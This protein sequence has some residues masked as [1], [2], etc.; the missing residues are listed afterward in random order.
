MRAVAQRVASARV[1]VAGELVGAIG[2][3]LLVYVGVAPGDEAGTARHLASRLA[4]MRVFPDKDGRMNR[5]LLDGPG[6]TLVVSQFT[7]FAD[8]TRGH[9]PSFMGAGSPELGRELCA[10]LAEELRTLGVSTVAEGRFGA[11]M[12]VESVNDGPVTI[13]AT[14]SEGTWQADCG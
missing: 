4:T 12:Q 14:T 13:V 5:S 2:P 3:G 11:N 7:L 6:A 8:L 10:A 9:R 1:T